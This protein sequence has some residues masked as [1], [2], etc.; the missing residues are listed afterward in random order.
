MP[1]GHIIPLARTIDRSGL[2]YMTAIQVESKGYGY[3]EGCWC[4]RLGK[5]A[6]WTLLTSG[7][8]EMFLRAYYFD[9]HD[10]SILPFVGLTRKEIT[11]GMATLSAFV[12]YTEYPVSFDAGFE[13]IWQNGA[14]K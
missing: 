12:E 6:D 10:T 4:A 13:F 5:G 9:D 1:G 3:L 2:L 8:E 14:D 7:G 11:A